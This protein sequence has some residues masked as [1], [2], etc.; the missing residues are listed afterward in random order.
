MPRA[1]VACLLFAVLSAAARFG[2]AQPPF[3]PPGR[4]PPPGGRPPFGP[5]RANRA[6][7]AL[8]TLDTVVPRRSPAEDAKAERG[9]IANADLELAAAG[10]KAPHGFELA[11]DAAYGYLG[12][13]TTDRTGFGVRLNSGVDLDG[14][15]TRQA[16]LTTT[17]KRL[18]SGLDRWFRFSIRGLAQEKFS[19]SSKQLYLK[20]E[21]FAADGSN[22]L[23]SISQNFYGSLE[24]LRR[25]VPSGA[26]GPTATA[27][28]RTYDLE[29]RTP[30]P[31]VDTLRLSVGFRGG[32]GPAERGEFLVDEVRLLPIPE[33]A[34]YAAH[35]AERSA[36]PSSSPPALA[37]LVALGGRWYYDPRD[38]ASRTPP[39]RFDHTNADRLY[40]LAG[41]LE[42]PFADNMSAWL[43]RGYLDKNGKRVEQDRY[44]EDNVVI[45]FTKTHLVLRSHNLPNH[46]TAVFPDVARAMDGN[47]NVIQ[48][49]DQTFYLSLEPK[50]N[51]GRQAMTS[52][53]DRYVMNP[54][55]IGVAVN[56]VVFFDPYDA[57]AVE[58]FW[59]LDRC[60]GHPSPQ[61]QY[62]YHKYPVCV[63]TP[64]IDD[65]TDHSPL[66]GFAFDGFPVYGP[67]EAA[68]V[69]AKDSTENPLNEF[70]V[71]ED[72]DRGPHYHVTPGKFPHMIGG[73]WGYVE[74]KN[75]RRG[76]P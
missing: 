26:T 68:G 67:Y 11:G 30:F 36:R 43:R 18:G 74:T 10:D 46:P 73:Y 1:L 19:S 52:I 4:F 53:A 29:F 72:P 40:Y 57:D 8:R 15:G 49:Q 23:D 21:F 60:C 14:D 32:D 45:T 2:V 66:I 25:D 48:E 47:P 71:H 16:A 20:C 59:R 51:P 24:Q 13:P 41:R 33:P 39:K 76:R 5:P 75:V 12:D 3:G 28:W 54:G 38:D 65:G 6:D 62:H 58:A 35:I 55:A 69:M 56:G 42:T 22:P 17:V 70:N 50:P 9:L 44:V 61:Q 64:W 37:K 27:I 63:K 34:E 31:E 7:A